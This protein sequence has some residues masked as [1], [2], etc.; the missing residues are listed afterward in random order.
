MTRC[1]SEFVRRLGAAVISYWYQLPKPVAV[2]GPQR[3]RLTAQFAP[4][5][6][7]P[8]G[9]SNRWPELIH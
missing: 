7:G 9:R 6:P 8:L 1:W 5:T 3:R 4:L 2:A